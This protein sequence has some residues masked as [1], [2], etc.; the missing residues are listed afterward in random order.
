MQANKYILV[1]L[2]YTFKQQKFKYI[3]MKTMISL[4]E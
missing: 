3:Y 1:Y 4:Y 2:S